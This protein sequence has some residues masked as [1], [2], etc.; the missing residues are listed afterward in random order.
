M[1]QAGREGHDR[2]LDPYVL[3]CLSSP[4]AL[5]GQDLGGSREI[6]EAQNP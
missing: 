3:E 5:A 6:A 1:L 2:Y 4:S